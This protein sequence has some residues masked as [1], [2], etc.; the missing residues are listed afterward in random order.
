M[1]ITSPPQCIRVFA[2]AAAPRISLN[3]VTTWKNFKKPGF[4]DPAKPSSYE[5]GLVPSRITW[6][7]QFV[8]EVARVIKACKV[9]CWFPFFWLCYSQINGNLGTVAA[10]MTLN[11]TP[12]DLIQTIGPISTII[13]IPIF[14]K[15]IYPALGKAGIKF[16]PIK[17]IY[18]GFLVAGLAM[19]YSA[20]LQKFVYEKSPCH[21][22]Q[23]SACEDA[24][25]FPNPAPIN[26]WVIIGPHILI[27]IAEIFTAITSLEYAFTKAPKQMK[28][29][30]VAFSQFQIAIAAALNFAL[31]SVNIEERFA[32]LFGAFAITAVIAG[33]LFYL[34]FLELDG[35]EA[36]LN[37]IG[38]GSRDGFIDPHPKS[39]DAHV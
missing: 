3:P 23:P 36:V 20:I 18:A 27:S 10:G 4:W 1:F 7:D 21:D 32:W 24:D 39:K 15:V 9:F 17:R 2:I 37:T 28:S 13:L 22:N 35:A 29:F 11:G 26:V 16:T 5:E 38:T 6:D 34:T 33:T 31:T 19:L 25:G 8:G 12:N 14:D 30:V